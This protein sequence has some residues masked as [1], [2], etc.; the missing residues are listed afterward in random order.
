MYKP[1]SYVS[2]IFDSSIIGGR[3]GEREEEEEKGGRRG[4][5][6]V[7]EWFSVLIMSILLR[8]TYL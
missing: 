1:K 3:G 2:Y 4:R 6:K 7:G 5:G 8:E